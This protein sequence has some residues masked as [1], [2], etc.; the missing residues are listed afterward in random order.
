MPD[1]AGLRER[2]RRAY[3]VGRA[4]YAVR[5]AFIVFPAT[6]LCVRETGAVWTC[7]ALGLALFLIAAAARWRQP[8]GVLAVAAGLRA[9]ALPM[10]TALVLCR[11]APSWSVGA[12]LCAT[13]GL[14]SGAFAGMAL[15]R[16]AASRWQQFGTAAV[17]TGLTATLGCVGMGLGTAA[18]AVVGVAL[19]AAAVANVP[20]PVAG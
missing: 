9:G 2:A 13:A 10:A 18:G 8:Q 19:G 5:V 14:V 12:G 15:V 7:A 4:R 6:A 17:V 20:R 11:F 3:E 16:S 1:P